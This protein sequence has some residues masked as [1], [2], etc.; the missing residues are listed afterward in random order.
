M[1]RTHPMSLLTFFQCI[2]AHRLLLCF[3]EL[4]QKANSWGCSTELWVSWDRQH[5][6]GRLGRSGENVRE[7]EF[8]VHI[9]KHLRESVWHYFSISF[10]FFIFQSTNHI[11]ASGVRQGS[12]VKSELSDVSKAFCPVC[13]CVWK[14]HYHH[15]ESL[16]EQAVSRYRWERL[17]Q[18]LKLLFPYFLL[19]KLR[20]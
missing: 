13:L 20:N 9:N 18:S 5:S 16:K 10:L 17:S 15:S 6:A 7:A 8:Y 19:Y 4:Y 3:Q 11:L 1:F 12:E 14:M 2:F